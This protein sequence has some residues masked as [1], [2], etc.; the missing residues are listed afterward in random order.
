MIDKLDKL[1]A[2]HRL[3]LGLAIP[4]LGGLLPWVLFPVYMSWA[5][6]LSGDLGWNLGWLSLRYGLL[7]GAMI[8]LAGVGAAFIARWWALVLV[9]LVVMVGCRI[10]FNFSIELWRYF[11]IY[12]PLKYLSPVLVEAFIG[13]ALGLAVVR[14]AQWKKLVAGVTRPSR[15][16][17]NCPAPPPVPRAQPLP[18]QHGTAPAEQDDIARVVAQM[19]REY[20]QAKPSQNSE[21][22]NQEQAQ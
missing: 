15:G 17:Q 16:V 19:Q 6:F 8:L 18:E 1:S 7:I 11:F 3:L 14:L 13:A 2:K 22:P 21:H 10:G 12:Q 9:P 20:A 4:F 5:I